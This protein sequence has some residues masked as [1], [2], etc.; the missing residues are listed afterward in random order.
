MELRAIE[1][2][3]F[4]FIKWGQSDAIIQWHW[5]RDQWYLFW[6][7]S[8]LYDSI[9]LQ[10]KYQKMKKKIKNGF[11]TVHETK[12]KVVYSINLFYRGFVL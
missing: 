7:E 12:M 4:S 8:N 1:S 5:I 11:D 3:E 6:L 10:N 2:D 9:V